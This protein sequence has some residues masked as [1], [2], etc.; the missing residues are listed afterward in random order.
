M[1]IKLIADVTYAYKDFK[2]V[3]FFLFIGFVHSNWIQNNKS[4]KKISQKV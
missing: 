1:K 2:R 3:F 4:K